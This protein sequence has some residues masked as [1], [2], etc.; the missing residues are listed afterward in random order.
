MR[1]C[2]S[3]A[4][5]RITPLT[6]A[7]MATATRTSGPAATLSPVLTAQF[8]VVAVFTPDTMIVVEAMLLA[9][10]FKD[11]ARLATAIVSVF[12]MCAVVVDSRAR[13]GLRAAVGVV[14]RA[15]A[16]RRSGRAATEAA[17]VAAALPASLDGCLDADSMRA[18]HRLIELALGLKVPTDATS[19]GADAASASVEDE[20]AMKAACG[21][22]GDLTPFPAFD[23]AVR[24]VADAAENGRGVIITGDCGSGKSAIV[25]C[26]GEYIGAR[27]AGGTTRGPV[28]VVSH[29][30]MPRALTPAEVYG[31]VNE[32]NENEWHTGIVPM[33]IGGASDESSGRCWIILDGQ[34]D[35]ASCDELCSI[36]D[37]SHRLS[38]ANSQRITVPHSVAVVIEALT[39]EGASPSL[40]AR[41]PLVHVPAALV[42]ADARNSCW[43]RRAA[44]AYH[45]SESAVARLGTCL[46]GVL[47]DVAAFVDGP[48]CA[49]FRR[50]S[51]EFAGQSLLRALE[52]VIKECAAAAAGAL[53]D[54]HSTCAD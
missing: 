24:A 45:L 1:L 13:R 50:A 23:S 30:L 8:R 9:N 40:C 4:D 12:E 2:V 41:F 5:I 35:G 42:P 47:P 38:L 31:A 15:A 34:V 10:G 29:W 43:L 19:F 11:A 26:A 52:A 14:T 28:R 46:N 49:R 16:L 7:I 17:A 32:A 27:H 20:A 39:L 48:E 21:S 53:A 33:L 22:A 3:G 25:R 37:P 18:V 51:T 44:R 36:A 6:F 54:A